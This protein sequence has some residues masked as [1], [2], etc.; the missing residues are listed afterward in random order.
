MRVATAVCLLISAMLLAACTAAPHPTSPAKPAAAPSTSPPAGARSSSSPAPSP[1]APGAE[2][3]A[4]AKDCV[5]I[6]AA[7]EREGLA[8]EGNWL[9]EHYPGWHKTS[10][11]LVMGT[12]GKTY[13]LVSLV[14]PDKATHD[15]CFDITSFYGKF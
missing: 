10:Q 5:V 11:S 6:S 14:T 13:D 4:P 7:N 1:T 3:G 15:V 9:H 2:A 8:S 12:G